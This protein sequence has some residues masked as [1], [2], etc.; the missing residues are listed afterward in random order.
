MGDHATINNP[1]ATDAAF[2]EKGK[3]K[4]Q[5]PEISMEEDSS[6][7]SENEN[8]MADNDDEDADDQLEPISQDNI[9]SGG[10][11]TRGKN[12]DW[13]EVRDN[14]ADAMEDDEDDDEDYQGGDNDDQMHD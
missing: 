5:D 12:I 3:G 10:R 6:S 8:E 14:N 7:E 11:R 9:I 4:A 13:Q 1:S 2:A